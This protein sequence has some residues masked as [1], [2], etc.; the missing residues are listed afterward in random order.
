MKPVPGSPYHSH[1]QP[2]PHDM[3][4]ARP[5]EGVRLSVVNPVSIA[6]VWVNTG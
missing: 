1:S 2:R 3:I 5:P 6:T 4:R